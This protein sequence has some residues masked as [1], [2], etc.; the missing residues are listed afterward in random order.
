M[1]T[2]YHYT[3]ATGLKGIV[4]SK[5]LWASDYRFLNDT[6]EF[7][8]GWD[9]ISSEIQR[10]EHKIKSASA[11]AWLTLKW[12]RPE[13]E[14]PHVFALVASLSTE[15]DLLSQWRGYNGGR[16]Y[17]IGI[18]A[19]W[20]NQNAEPQQFS[21]FPIVYSQNE[22]QKAAADA[23]RLLLDTL[24]SVNN[25]PNGESEVVKRW[26]ERALRVALAF[27]DQHFSE[28]HEYRLAYVGRH[29]PSGIQVR[30][31][32]V[33]LV[34]YL[35]CYFDKVI[36]NNPIFHPQNLGLERVI[37]GPALKEQ[38]VYAADALLA[39]HGMRFEIIKSSI[40]YVAD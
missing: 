30:S 17:A 8:Y 25:D 7:R 33:G 20:L 26:W 10:N 14:R 40:P 18:N 34:P 2:L 9:I 27:K 37:V 3:T 16:G 4:D 32:T 39:S 12:L 29:W 15:G 24:K 11:E 35:P 13:I 1:T 6:S 19:D 36:V 21:L 38:Q 31:G 5:S 23:I 28:E 22:Q